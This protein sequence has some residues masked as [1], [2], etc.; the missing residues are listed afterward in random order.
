MS[1]VDE[2]A[3]AHRLRTQHGYGARRIAKALGIS[4]YAAEQL[5]ARPLSGAADA[6]GEPM[7][8]EVAEV[9]EAPVQ[10]VAEP[11]GQVARVAEPVADEPAAPQL[12]VDLR[13]R[14]QLLRVLMALLKVGI[15]APVAVDVAVRAFAD[16]YYRALTRG[17]LRPGQPYEIQ[18]R[19][20]AAA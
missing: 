9:A 13:R 8:G 12:R 15:L 5:L 6:P 11:V 1:A 7:A 16:A 10:P 2:H 19:V 3:E 4:R 17:E 14:P 20:R 18:V